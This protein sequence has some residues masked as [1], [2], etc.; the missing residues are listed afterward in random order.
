M[1]HVSCA[2]SIAVLRALAIVCLLASC[3]GHD[4]NYIPYAMKG[5]NVY[6][7]GDGDSREYFAGFVEA[8]YLDRDNALAQCAGFARATAV[9]NY[10][11]NWRYVCCTATANSNCATKVR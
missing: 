5:M 11:S 2:N 3:D 8:S 9:Q 6:V 1:R 7:Y 4:G 10:L